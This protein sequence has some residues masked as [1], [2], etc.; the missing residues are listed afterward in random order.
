MINDRQRLMVLL[1]NAGVFIK[2]GYLD[3]PAK[4]WKDSWSWTSAKKR[5][6]Q[7][8][9]ANFKV[10]EAGKSSFDRYVYTFFLKFL[11]QYVIFVQAYLVSS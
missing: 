7:F 5:R 10:Q 2:D 3:L 6:I 9:I 8:R 4:H 1:T 11:L